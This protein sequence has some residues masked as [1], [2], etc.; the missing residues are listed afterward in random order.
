VAK[1]ESSEYYTPGVRIIL[2]TPPPLDPRGREPDRTHE[3]TAAY[4][5]AVRTVGRERGV[6]VAD[7]WTA[8]WEAAGRQFEGLPAFLTDGL[9]LSEAGYKARVLNLHSPGPYN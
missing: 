8:M 1:D 6:P 5:E 7:I 4:A 3:T 9:H 2:I